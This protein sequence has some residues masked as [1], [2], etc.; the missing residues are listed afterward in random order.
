MKKSKIFLYAF[1]DAFGIFAYIA[2]VSLVMNN[3]EKLFGPA[4]QFWAAV[5]MLLLFVFSASA[6]GLLF[7]GRPVYLYLQGF[8]KEGI[9]LIFYTLGILCLFVLSVFL[10]LALF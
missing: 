6:T 5:A 9:K 8:K 10:Y 1:L 3:A 7:F 4:S 2:V